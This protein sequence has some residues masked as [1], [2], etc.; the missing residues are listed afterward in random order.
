[1]PD[2]IFFRESGFNS[3]NTTDDA[4]VHISPDFDP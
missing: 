1:L 2:P 3:I 4:K